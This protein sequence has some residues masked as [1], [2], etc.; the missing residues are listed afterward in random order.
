[1]KEKGDE[2]LVDISI[3][4]HSFEGL[5]TKRNKKNKK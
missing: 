1:M 3:E 5:N 2:M 4:N